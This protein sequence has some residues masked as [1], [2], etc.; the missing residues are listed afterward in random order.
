MEFGKGVVACIRPNAGSL[1]GG[2][3]F[4]NG[5]SEDNPPLPSQDLKRIGKSY[6]SNVILISRFG[7]RLPPPIVLT[8]LWRMLFNR[9]AI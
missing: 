2:M 1:T 9:L 7:N 6:E 4:P 5:H 8:W 3:H